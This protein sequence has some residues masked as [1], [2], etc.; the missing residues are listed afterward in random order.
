M[1]IF[2]LYKSIGVLA[3]AITL[4]TS[5]S[6]D[7]YWSDPV[8]ETLPALTSGS[9]DFSNYVALGASFSSGDSDNALF[10]ASQMNSFPNTLA[11]AFSNIGGGEFTQPMM[12]DNIGGLL[13][14]GEVY[15]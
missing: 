8:T 12:N 9:A 14:N 3:L 1:K 5:C 10:I 13:L 11:G 6:N 2:N 15:Y 4:L 7:Q